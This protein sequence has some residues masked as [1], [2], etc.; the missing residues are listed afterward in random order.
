ML[1]WLEGPR[2]PGFGYRCGSGDETGALASLGDSWVRSVGGVLSPESDSETGCI[3][4]GDDLQLVPLTLT[5]LPSFERL[6]AVGARISLSATSAPHTHG[7][8]M[9]AGKFGT[10]AWITGSQPDVH[11]GCGSSAVRTWLTGGFGEAW[12]GR[13]ISRAL[14]EEP[15]QDPFPTP[16][17]S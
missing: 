16:I 15:A 13:S 3:G 5:R 2:K 11:R 7:P 8:F 9:P 17:R 6:G 14:A 4:H 1:E 12:G 10:P